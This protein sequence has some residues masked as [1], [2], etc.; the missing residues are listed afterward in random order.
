MR[1]SY[2]QF[3]LALSFIVGCKN[4]WDRPGDF[5]EKGVSEDSRPGN[6]EERMSAMEALLDNHIFPQVRDLHVCVCV[7]AFDEL[8]LYP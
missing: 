7:Y 8:Q 4:R 3:I 5:E 6:P 2:Q 1:M